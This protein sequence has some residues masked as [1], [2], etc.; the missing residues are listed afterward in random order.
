MIHTVM[1]KFVQHSVFVKNHLNTVQ[2]FR[3][4]R[5][6]AP[7]SRVNALTSRG[8]KKTMDAILKIKN[9][10]LMVGKKSLFNGDFFSITPR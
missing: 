4:F 7:N 5:E 10:T 1:I 8:M 2:R 9:R 3:S 6:I